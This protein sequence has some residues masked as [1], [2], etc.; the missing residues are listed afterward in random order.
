[1]PHKKRPAVKPRELR[2]KVALGARMRIGGSWKDLCILNMSSRGMMGRATPPPPAGSYVEVRRGRHVIVARVVWT[3]EQ[4]FGMS[5]QDAIAIDD[6]L[7]DRGRPANDQQMND[8][9]KD[10]RQQPRGVSLAADD[11]SRHLGR[12]MQFAVVMVFA[13]SFAAAA[14]ASLQ[15]ALARPLAR[16]AATLGN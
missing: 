11:N 9:P 12:M 10:R 6:V 1:M 5:T 8:P 16:V 14:A 4:Q 15:D 7:Q 13:L 3:D 2:R